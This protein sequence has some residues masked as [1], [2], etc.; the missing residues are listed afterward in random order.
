VEIEDRLFVLAIGIDKVKEEEKLQ[1][2]DRYA[3]NFVSPIVA[4]LKKGGG[5]GDTFSTYKTVSS[6]FTFG[7]NQMYER[8][9]K[10]LSFQHTRVLIFGEDIIKDEVLFKEVLDAVGRSH[11]FHRNMY[12]FAVPGRAEEVFKIKPKYTSVLAMYITGIAENNL[13]QSSI[14]KMPAYQ[15]YDNL[16]NFDGNTV[17]PSLRASE[18]EAKVSGVGIIKNYKLIGYLDDKDSET[19]NWLNNKANGGLIAAKYNEID[20]PYIYNDFNTTLV[21]DKVEG[22]KLYLTYSMEIEGSAEEYTWSE[23]LMDQ[24][25]L[26]TL[27]KSLAKTIEDRSKAVIDKFKNEFKVDLIGINSYLRKHHEP[28]YKSIEGDYEKFFTNNMIINI[29]A[30]VSIRRVGTIE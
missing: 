28:I 18:D 21:L 1:P 16:A 10:K 27:E 22:D 30:K 23:N 20:I 24:K 29:K 9:D 3:I 19:L 5:G 4:A 12:V 11:E 14:Y 8:M 17:I 7:L 6:I 25:L 15:M 26:D 2:T 13:Y